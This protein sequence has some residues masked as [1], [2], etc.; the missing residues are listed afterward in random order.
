MSTPLVTFIVPA[1]NAE[2]TLGRTLDALA[3]QTDPRW[4]AIVVDDGSTDST[5]DCAVHHPTRPLLL[6]QSNGGVSV[7]RN[8]GFAHASAPFACFLD[9]DDTVDADYVAEMLP[10]A[11]RT[12]LG[13]ICGHRFVS[14]P[15]EAITEAPSPP[16]AALTLPG[17]LAMDPPPIMSLLHRTETLRSAAHQASLFDAELGMFEDW[18]LLRRLP[19]GARGRT[20]RP[21]ASYWCEPGSASD[22]IDRACDVGL[23]LIARYGGDATDAWARQHRITSLAAATICERA[24]LASRLVGE[25][26]PTQPGDAAH[27][28]SAMRWH[29]MRRWAVPECD[30]PAH[31]ARARSSA[32]ALLRSHDWRRDALAAIDAWSRDVWGDALDAAAREVCDGGRVVLFGAGRNGRRAAQAAIRRSIACVVSDDDPRAHV[33]WSRVRAAI[34]AD[35]GRRCRD[36]AGRRR[37]DRIAQPARPRHH[38]VRAPSGVIEPVHPKAL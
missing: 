21:L 38:T 28:A 30:L 14:P 29:A 9:A 15:G 4:T 32:G 20:H 25:L 27:L 2:R 10:L 5:A 37:A 16:D 22:S 18:D 26:G 12:P 33:R 7:A 23:G 11:E 24:T 17:L 36:H 8:A 31:V 19:T 6:R 1:Y 35:L 3:A 34:G 13:A